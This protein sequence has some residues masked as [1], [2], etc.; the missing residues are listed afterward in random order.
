MALLFK[1]AWRNVWR[2]K[3]RTLIVISAI[4]LTMG[5]MIFYDGLMA[6]FN[7][8]IYGNAIKI[9]GGNIQIHAEGF[10]DKSTQLP[11]LGL[12]DSDTVISSVKQFPEVVAVSKRIRTGGLATSREGAFGIEIVGIDPDAEKDISLMAS[13]IAEGRFLETSDGDQLLIGKGLADEMDV[14]VGDRISVAGSSKHE[15][16]RTRTL[17]IVGI[18]DLGMADI[19]KQYAYIS[20]DEARSLYGLEGTETEIA[21]YLKRIGQEDPVISALKAQYP[22]LEIEKYDEAF[23]ELKNTVGTKDAVLT[24]FSFIILLI[25]GIGIMN[26]LLMAVYERTREI[27]VLSALGLNPGQ[28]T[29]LFLMEGVLIGLIGLVIGILFG[30]GINLSLQQVGLDYT[31]YADVASY[32]ALISDRIYP[33]MGIDKLPLRS[34]SVFVISLASSFFPAREAARNEPAESL[35]YV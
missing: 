30:L 4:T 24:I 1:L 27:G 13:N 18:Y 35:H 19:E 9:L 31:G 2:Q 20:L 7:Q 3:R 22:T 14:K 12:S 6:G 29:W 5:M 16:M 11:L 17:T 10:H 28:I 26:L 34:I 21:I 8:A 25:S 32:M 33:S 15:Q 23:P